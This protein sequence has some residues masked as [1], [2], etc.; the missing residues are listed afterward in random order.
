MLFI[1]NVTAWSEP[2]RSKLEALTLQSS[3]PADI[4][5]QKSLDSLG[6]P[7]QDMYKREADKY[8]RDDE[9]QRKLQEALR[10]AANVDVVDF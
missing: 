2:I 6:K 1:R 10:N 7:L 5:S 4:E 9:D 8:K 3:D